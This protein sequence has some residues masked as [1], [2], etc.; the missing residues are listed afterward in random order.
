MI[1][2]KIV[3]EEGGNESGDDNDDGTVSSMFN[4]VFCVGLLMVVTTHLI[5]HVLVSATAYKS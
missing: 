4:A 2:V 1:T 5:I 3:G